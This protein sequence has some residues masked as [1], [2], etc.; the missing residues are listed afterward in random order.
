MVGLFLWHLWPLD[1]NFLTRVCSVCMCVRHFCT[2][3]IAV[4]F[5]CLNKQHW[6]QVPGLIASCPKLTPRKW[7]FL[8]KICSATTTIKS[9]SNSIQMIL[10]AYLG[11]SL[12][13]GCGRHQCPAFKQHPCILCPVWSGWL[14]TQAFRDKVILEMAL[15]LS[16]LCSLSFSLF[17]DLE[18]LSSGRWAPQ[19]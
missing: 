8:L 9:Q 10:H 13:A 11:L 15:S 4:C 14:L 1:F 3:K 7:V 5:S 19:L 6:P 18:V 16:F 12:Q 17:L 2:L